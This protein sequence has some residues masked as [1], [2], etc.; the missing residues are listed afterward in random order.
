M[1]SGIKPVMR[2]AVGRTIGRKTHITPSDEESKQW[3]IFEAAKH[4][5]NSP[6]FTHQSSTI[7]ISIDTSILANCS[8]NVDP[9]RSMIGGTFIAPDLEGTERLRGLGN[10]PDNALGG[11]KP[12]RRYQPLGRFPNR[13]GSFLWMWHRVHTK[14]LMKIILR[15]KLDKILLKSESM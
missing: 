6:R 15:I 3:R 5:K 11:S 8:K 12:V 4:A 7:S 10:C 1:K 14:G 9:K 13:A 2:R